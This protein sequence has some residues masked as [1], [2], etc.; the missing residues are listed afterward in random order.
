[1]HKDYVPFARA[2]L[3]C[4]VKSKKAFYGLEESEAKALASEWSTAIKRSKAHDKLMK[5]WRDGDPGQAHDIEHAK[6]N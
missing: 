4:G 5:L 6:R 2:F 1:M 3:K